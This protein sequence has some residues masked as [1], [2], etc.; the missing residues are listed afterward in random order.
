M[1]PITSIQ[2]LTFVGLK[3][4]FSSLDYTRNYVYQD[5]VKMVSTTKR[6][7]LFNSV[8]GLS[9]MANKGVIP[10]NVDYQT[11]LSAYPTTITANTFN[12][13]VA[14]AQV[15]LDDDLYNVYDSLPQMMRQA[16]ELTRDI[17]VANIYN[18]AVSSTQLGP[19]GVPLIDT[20][21]PLPGKSVTWSNQLADFAVPSMAALEA[22]RLLS[23]TIPDETGT[24][25]NA[26]ITKF[27]IPPQYET[28]FERL[29]KSP[30]DPSTAARSIN[31]FA[32]EAKVVID[33]RF[34]STANWFAMTDACTRS[35][36][37]VILLDRAAA[38]MTMDNDFNSN[39]MLYKV[40]GR[41]ATG[42]T[43]SRMVLGSI[44]A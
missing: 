1:A 27:A 40:Q 14:V 11:L 25:I 8:A 35:D 41:W 44:Q 2:W 20:A 31:P 37:G 5:L 34:T 32:N 4:V 42:I 39:S 24:L 33:V 43:N 16:Y 19:D 18:L 38:D 22:M 28:I 36:A 13:G 21:H 30:D 29:M 15:D 17:S 6:Q 10:A 12:T 9:P 26:Q 3:S 7:E 23:R